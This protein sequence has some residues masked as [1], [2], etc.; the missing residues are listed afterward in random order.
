MAGDASEHVGEPR[1]RVYIVHFCRDD[2][3]VH[4]GGALPAAIGTGEQPR[5]SSQS[6]SAQCS[7]SRI[8]G[9]ADATVIEEARKR[10]PAL[11]HVVHGLGDVVATRELGA[12]FAHPGFEFGNE[13]R[14]SPLADTAALLGAHSIDRTLDLEQFVDTADGFQRQWRDHQRRLTLDLASRTG[15]DVGQREERSTR[16]RPARRFQDRPRGAIGFVKLRVAAV[17]VSLQ[18]AGPFGQMRSWMLTAAV[19]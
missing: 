15:F 8:V 12:F 17:G 14:A 1:L 3:A 2:E 13:R 9:Q 7:F 10:R 18:L 11:Q 16:V 5:L 4:G 19:T 6:N